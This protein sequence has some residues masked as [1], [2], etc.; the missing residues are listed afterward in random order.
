MPQIG[1]EIG[2]GQYGVVYS[3]ESWGKHK[4]CAIKSVVP[5]DDKHWNDLALEFFYT[6]NIPDHQRVVNLRGSAI[7]YL[8]GGGTSPAVLLV[9]DRLARDLYTA[10]K[11]GLEWSARLQVARDVVEGLRYLH[12]QGLVHRD[13][14]LKNVLVS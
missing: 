10:I 2:R 9:M 11:Q 8:Y 3:C 14:K 6:K 13:V 12:S 5:P 4:P 1:R 7:D